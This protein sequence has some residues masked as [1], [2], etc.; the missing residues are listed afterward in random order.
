[1]LSPL[2]EEGDY[3]MDKDEVLIV[4]YNTISNTILLTNGYTNLT[5]NDLKNI[6]IN[7]I[8]KAWQDKWTYVPKKEA[9]KSIVVCQ[10]IPYVIVK[11]EFNE[12]Y[13]LEKTDN[14]YSKYNK[15]KTYKNKK[16]LGINKHILKSEY[17][18]YDPI[19]NCAASIVL[20]DYKILDIKRPM[21]FKGFIINHTEKDNIHLGLVFINNVDKS[22]VPKQKKECYESKWLSKNELIDKYGQF[23]QWSKY[24][25]DYLVDNEL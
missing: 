5:T 18:Y 16:S 8:Y 1:M 19:F 4:P 20:D 2:F 3:I 23:D 25:I 11:N 22:N 7:D 9:E 15:E 10:L 21:R 14:F 6:K 12:Y 13:I 17:G 24:I